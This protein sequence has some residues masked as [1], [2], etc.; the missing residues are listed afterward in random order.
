M[1]PPKLMKFSQRVGV[2]P[3]TK[4]AQLESMDDDLR[5]SLWNL[6]TLFYW[7]N[8]RTRD[9]SKPG[10]NYWTLETSLA[11]LITLLWLNHFKRPVDEIEKYWG[12][13]VPKIR[14]YFFQAEWFEVYDF[15]EFVALNGS[16]ATKGSFVSACNQ[17]LERENSA[18]RFVGDRLAEVTSHAEIES[19]ETAIELAN[20]FAGVKRHL[21]SA[22]S[23]MSDRTSP[24]Y[25]NS[26]KES[27]SAVESLVKQVT[28]NP[29]AEFGDA[30]K[31]L[32]RTKA[33]HPALKKAFSALYGYTS[34]A[35]GIRHALLD[36]PTLSKSDARFML[37]CC[38]AFVSY[39]IEA[40]KP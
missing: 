37:V 39:V 3:L 20:P 40:T 9:R 1:A 4:L 31:E 8:A 16:D 30:M 35:Q 38:S 14:Q 27:I 15:V 18:Y 19:I 23:L 12:N 5:A 29:A 21:E 28:K 33:L 17:Y 2:K 11:D 34:D 13:F 36:E 24:D 7:E 10:G 22:L 25:R 6:I 26:I 32:E